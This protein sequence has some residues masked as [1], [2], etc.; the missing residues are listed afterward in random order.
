MQEIE[1]QLSQYLAFVANRAVYAIRSAWAATSLREGLD[2]TP[3]EFM[4]L[5]MLS[6][7]DGLTQS[8][9]TVVAVRDR[10]TVTRLVDGLVKKGLV[11]RESGSGDKRI[12]RTC[13]TAR[14]KRTHAQAVSMAKRLRQEAMA[15]V[16]PADLARAMAVLHRVRCNLLT[17]R[18][19]PVPVE[20]GS[21]ESGAEV[22]VAKAASVG[23]H[24][25]R[26]ARRRG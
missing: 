18:D 8:E 14:G 1:Q 15:G 3:E 19:G 25:S 2:V 12:V 7:K 13:T 23:T 6:V 21:S 24:S 26:A 11:R 5:E 16:D 22:T 20:A 9:I 17:Y 4:V 10:T